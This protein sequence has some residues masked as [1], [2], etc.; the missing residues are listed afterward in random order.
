[1]PIFQLS[2]TLAMGRG[3]RV[4]LKLRVGL[5]RRLVPD[6]ERYEEQAEK[7]RNG[8]RIVEKQGKTLESKDREIIQLRKVLNVAKERVNLSSDVASGAVPGAERDE[9]HAENLRNT[10]RRIKQQKKTLKNK[11]REIFQLRNELRAAG[12]RV[13]NEQAVKIKRNSTIFRFSKAFSV[14]RGAKAFLSLH[15]G[16]TRGA[17]P[18]LEQYEEQAGDLANVRQRIEARERTL[19]SKNRKISRL[20]NELR[21]A[22]ERVNLES[23]VTSVT[24]SHERYD[25][26]AENLR[27]AQQWIRVQKEMLEGKDREISRLKN[28]LRATK[29]PAESAPNGRLGP[30]VGGG[31]EA[32]TLPDFVII[33]A[34]K[35]GTT[36]L[37]D[38]LTRHPYVERAALK[39]PH[40]F[41]Y[42]FE[43]GIEWYRSQFPPPR[44][45]EGR[46]SITGEATPYLPHPPVPER[47][48]KVI[49]QARLIVLLRNPVDRVYSLY[50]REIRHVRETRPFEEAIEASPGYLTGSIYVDQLRRWS[51]FFGDEQML[52]LKSEGFF[53]RELE[54][55]KVVMRFLELPDWEPEGATKVR[56]KGRYE[57][58][59]D[60]A[61]RRWLEDYFE[62]HN[63][64]L[65]EYL[66]TD[67]GW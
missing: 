50:H 18:G 5:T 48:A 52:V 45:K 62:P 63:R 23:G 64:R 20:K 1:M 35:C 61:T 44:W 43:K 6:L 13:E 11:D 46:R 8:W 31:A 34:G 36:S 41:D 25:K 51:K 40:Y 4:F 3:A 29:E 49:P 7:L 47:M 67:L 10:Q 56:N 28:E 14:T 37:Y 32:G 15:G 42:N 60:P 39:E 38:L 30:R 53:E 24:M 65:Y 9:E 55:L 16:L 2:K 58:G 17:V 57:Q 21:A 12:E 22:K 54:T 19:R 59:M 66:G 27:N 26:Q 33:G